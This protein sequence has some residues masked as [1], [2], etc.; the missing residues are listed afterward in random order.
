LINEKNDERSNENLGGLVQKPDVD[1]LSPTLNDN[2]NHRLQE[3]LRD[4]NEDIGQIFTDSLVKND[5]TQQIPEQQEPSKEKSYVNNEGVFFDILAK[6][7]VDNIDALNEKRLHRKSLG[8]FQPASSIHS[9]SLTD[10]RL[11]KIFKL[12]KAL[13]RVEKKSWKYP[14]RIPAAANDHYNPPQLKI[15]YNELVSLIEDHSK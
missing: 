13:Q 3:L 4:Q 8:S 9:S 11:K 6:H 15:N 12:N 14:Y 1:I 10:S 7:G 2:K 5:K